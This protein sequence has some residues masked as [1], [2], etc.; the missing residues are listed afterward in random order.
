M[1]K[2]KNGW[3]TKWDGHAPKQD[4]RTGI[5][6][7]VTPSLNSDVVYVEI[8]ESAGTNKYNTGFKTSRVSTEAEVDSLMNDTLH[9][10]NWMN[11]VPR[12]R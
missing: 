1:D 3:F 9:H 10:F 7:S 5:M 11:S 6:I 4:G 8:Y 12:G 2:N